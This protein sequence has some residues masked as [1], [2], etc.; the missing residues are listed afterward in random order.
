MLPDGPRAIT[1][2]EQ[3]LNRQMG[4]VGR[5]I[6]ALAGELPPPGILKPPAAPPPAPVAPAEPAGAPPASSE[7]TSDEVRET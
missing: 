2:I 4:A 7:P 1:A 3:M 6:V 5:R